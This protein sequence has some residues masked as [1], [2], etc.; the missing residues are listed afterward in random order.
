MNYVLA[1]FAKSER[2]WVDALCDVIADN[3]D[4]IVKGADFD[5]SEWC[6]SGDAGQ[7]VW[8]LPTQRW[9]AR[10]QLNLSKTR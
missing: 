4:L 1:D 7:G 5:L 2:P 9:C 3:A 10:G 6:A 8:R